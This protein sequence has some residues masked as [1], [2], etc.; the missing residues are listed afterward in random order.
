MHHE[1]SN[2]HD[3]TSGCPRLIIN[4][5]HTFLTCPACEFFAWWRQ[6]NA[7]EGWSAVK[8]LVEIKHAKITSHFETS[9]NGPVS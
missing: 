7:V 1:I 6:D 2:R 5:G 9:N 8:Q 3:I 4:S